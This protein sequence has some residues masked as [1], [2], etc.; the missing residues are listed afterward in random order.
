MADN[1]VRPGLATVRFPVQ[2]RA[3]RDEAKLPAELRLGIVVDGQ[4]RGDHVDACRRALAAVRGVR[5]AKQWRLDLPA[6]REAAPMRWL[7]GGSRAVAAA[8]APGSYKRMAA[9]GDTVAGVARLSDETRAAIQAARLDVVVNLSG[10][11]LDA[12]S[13]ELPLLGVWFYR[14]FDPAHAEQCLRPVLADDPTTETALCRQRDGAADE[15]LH[16]GAFATV[17]FSP[18]LNQDVVARG[19]LDWVA[20]VCR[21]WLDTRVLPAEPAAPA[22]PRL[23]LG[24]PRAALHRGRLAYAHAR[25]HWRSLTR[26]GQWNVGVVPTSLTTLLARHQPAPTDPAR[27]EAMSAHTLTLGDQVQWLP[28]PKH[29][30]FYA[31]PFAIHVD[32][33]LHVL[34]EDLDLNGEARGHIAVF[35]E[36]DTGTLQGPVPV[37]SAPFHLSYPCVFQHDGAIFCVPETF[38]NNEAALFRATDFPHGWERVQP[39]VQ[40]CAVVDPTIFQHEGRWWLFAT[41]KETGSETKLLAWH[42]SDLFGEWQPHGWN[43]L[44]TD[45]RSARPAGPLFESAGRLFRPAQDCSQG[46]GGAVQI[47]EVTELTP[48]A[49]REQPSVRVTPDPTGA[50]PHGLHTI[51]GSGDV[52]VIDGVRNRVVLRP[53]VGQILQ[54]AGRLGGRLASRG[55][56]WCRRPVHIG[57]GYARA[58]LRAVLPGRVA[59]RLGSRGARRD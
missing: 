17:P 18:R 55:W 15:I 34:V 51:S 24:W 52:T 35:T 46:Y 37:L 56:G 42:A 20:R 47:L 12:A 40:G 57:H 13:A 11:R 32:G 27:P 28:A 4:T 45:V 59:V 43:P 58:L 41:T 25:E 50:Y 9:D 5:I 10:W 23:P 39:L 14:H 21:E 8:D 22:P 31:D 38:E 48:T 7:L 54:R 1:G 19:S 29:G 44:K 30:R 49:Y 53:F 3:R 2:V 16:R 6:R 33:R 36:D 26:H